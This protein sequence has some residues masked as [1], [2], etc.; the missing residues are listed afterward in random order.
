MFVYIV[1]LLLIIVGIYITLGKKEK[2]QKIVVIGED[3]AEIIE[4]NKID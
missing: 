3:T 2:A 4:E 1:L